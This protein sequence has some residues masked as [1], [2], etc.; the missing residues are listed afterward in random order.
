MTKPTCPE[1]PGREAVRILLH[2]A[3]GATA[4]DP[5]D[6]YGYPEY[7]DTS[8]NLVQCVSCRLVFTEHV[9]TSSED[10]DE[11]GGLEPRIIT[12]APILCPDVTIE[13]SVFRSAPPDVQR[14]YIESIA[15]Y[16]AGALGLSAVGLRACIEAVAKDAA[17][18]GG[19]VPTKH[20]DGVTRTTY[21]TDLK[22]KIAGLY[23]AHHITR[24]Q[25][26]ALHQLRFL[27]NEAAHIVAFPDV[28]ELTAAFRL[29]AHL[30]EGCFDLPRVAEA[31][32]ARR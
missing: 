13:V 21:R 18:D 14:V 12:A 19:D 5:D 32:H 1:C 28:S 4:P 7:W 8:W 15:A 29:V 17:I 2:S 20:Q 24:E 16:R 31:I 11:T 26:K 6:E 25:E 22:G 10:R 30:L 23:R 27:G 3:T 9:R